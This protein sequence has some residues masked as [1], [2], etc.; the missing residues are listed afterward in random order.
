MPIEFEDVFVNV[1][2]WRTL[3]KLGLA[4]MNSSIIIDSYSLENPLIIGGCSDNVEKRTRGT[5]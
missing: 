5:L 1:E 4:S 2:F 3:V